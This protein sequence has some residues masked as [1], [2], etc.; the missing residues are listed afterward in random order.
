MRKDHV[1]YN[2]RLEKSGHG[3]FGTQL[4]IEYKQT[5]PHINI[6]PQLGKYVFY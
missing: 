4:G 5:Q 6:K 3:T 2:F 1:V